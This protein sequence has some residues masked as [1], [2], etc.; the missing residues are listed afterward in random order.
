MISFRNHII[1]RINLLI[2]RGEY[3]CGISSQKS[4]FSYRNN[5]FKTCNMQYPHK[6]LL[7]NGVPWHYLY[8]LTDIDLH[9]ILSSQLMSVG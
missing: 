3:Y 8:D 7:K 6:I 2:Q 9:Y 1:S 5:T 4:Q